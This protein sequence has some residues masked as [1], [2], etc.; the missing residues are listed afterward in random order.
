MLAVSESAATAIDGILTSRDLPEGAGVRLS[1][2][3]A[4][5]GG[6]GEAGIRLDLVAEPIVGD[7]VIE[8]APVYIEPETARLL[9]DKVLDAEVSGD[10][11]RFAVKDQG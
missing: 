5:D 7:E 4:A 1:Q 8:D 2:E 9:D 11:V 6:A 10:Q 3:P